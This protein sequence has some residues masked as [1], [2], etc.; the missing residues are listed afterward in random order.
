CG[1]A[2]RRAADEAEGGA[3]AGGADRQ[4]VHAGRY[5]AREEVEKLGARRRSRVDV[6]RAVGAGA[7]GETEGLVTAS[8]AD[9]LAHPAGETLRAQRGQRCGGGTYQG[10]GQKNTTSRH[11]SSSRDGE[12]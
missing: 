6:V 11:D 5:G 8:E 7:G 2:H 4:P 10:D 1:A 12:K 9:Q 3:A